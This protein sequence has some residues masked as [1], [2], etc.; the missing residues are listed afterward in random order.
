MENEY[1]RKQLLGILRDEARVHLNQAVSTTSLPT[2]DF[3]P[4]AKA[5][6]AICGL[7]CEKLIM[8]PGTA[9]KTMPN[10]VDAKLPHRRGF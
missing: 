6:R 9:N 8:F 7:P 5:V 3:N 10:N 2:M 4:V 1:E